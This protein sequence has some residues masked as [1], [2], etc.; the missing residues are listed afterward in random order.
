MRPRP[1][2]PASQ[3]S[4]RVVKAGT[5]VLRVSTVGHRVVR[6]TLAVLLLLAATHACG[7]L[8][9]VAAAPPIACAGCHGTAPEGNDRTDSHG[10]ADQ[11][12]PPDPSREGCAGN[13]CACVCHT[14]AIAPA[15]VLAAPSSPGGALIPVCMEQ[16]P[17]GPPT[18]PE[19]PPRR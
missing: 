9:A 8:E 13:T 11:D 2:Q 16:L 14:V 6:A 12:C 10:D 4:I 19:R 17:W 15:P 1:R 3:E 5:R 18:P 7:G